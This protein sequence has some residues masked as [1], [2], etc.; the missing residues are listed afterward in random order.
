M[1]SGSRP[2][3]SAEPLASHYFR[4]AWSYYFVRWALEQTF[5]AAALEKMHRLTAAGPV[6]P[7]LAEEVRSMEAVF[8]GVHV[9]VCR[10]L[11]M[12]PMTFPDLGSGKGDGAD[13]APFAAWRDNLASDADVGQETWMMVPVFYDV[14]AQEDE[15]LALSRLGGAARNHRLRHA[16]RG[17][18]ARPG[19]QASDRE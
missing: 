7:S 10:Q 19:G 16:A 9:T 2:E 3:L 14:H 15:G 11:G 1:S 8:Y 4:R 5:D 18:R 12:T 17:D 6:P 13:A